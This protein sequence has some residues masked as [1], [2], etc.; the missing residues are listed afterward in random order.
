MAEKPHDHFDRHLAE[1]IWA[2]IPEH[3]REE[4]GLAD[5]PGV[6][7]GFVEVLAQQAATLR[8]SNDRLW[9]DEFIDLCA[10]W[11][12]PYIGELVATRMVSALNQRGRR[13]DV[14]K[15]IYY[16]RRA[17]TPRILE[18]LIADITGWEGK[19]VEEFRRLGRTRHRL[20]PHPLPLAGLLTGTL[21]GGWA[22]LRSAHGSELAD[23]PFDEFHHTPDVRPP[24]V[25]DGR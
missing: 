25:R 8:R 11:A 3:Y 23:S 17:G 5:P 19:L 15:T 2:T 14:A 20:D 9:D 21:P 1:K 7:R 6:L 22:N 4:D 10:E 16:R 18:E 12:I 24:R 13:V